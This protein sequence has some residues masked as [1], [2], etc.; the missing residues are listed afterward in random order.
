M[1]EDTAATADRVLVVQLELHL[2]R[3]PLTGRLRRAG[4]AEHAFVGWLGFLEALRRVDGAADADDPNDRRQ[5]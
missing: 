5:R 4:G 3:Q 2:D 1:D